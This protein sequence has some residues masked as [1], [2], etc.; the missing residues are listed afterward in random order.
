LYVKYSLS[1]RVA[2]FELWC[3]DLFKN[4]NGTILIG[5]WAGFVTHNLVTLSQTSWNKSLS[6]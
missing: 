5:Q 1:V 2:Y 4:V 3:L 6:L